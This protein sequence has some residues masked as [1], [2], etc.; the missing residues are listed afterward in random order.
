MII[1]SNNDWIIPAGFRER[2]FCVIEV[3][4]TQQKNHE[5]FKAIAEQMENG[6]REAMLYDMLKMEDVNVSDLKNFVRT[7]ALFEQQL[8]S[9]STFHKFWYECLQRGT[10]LKNDKQWTC[11][12]IKT[13]Q[14]DEYI[15]F[16]HIMGDRFP[17]TDSQFSKNL[18]DICSNIKNIRP[19]INGKRVRSFIFS[20]LDKCKLDFE[21][22]IGNTIAWEAII[23]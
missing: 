8:N 19:N 22:S 9:M 13:E 17:L 14:Y 20:D 1:A 23:E 4:N 3:A 15:E 11:R 7:E 6:G 2:R 18:N 5:Y 21:E 12:T 10:I 16:T